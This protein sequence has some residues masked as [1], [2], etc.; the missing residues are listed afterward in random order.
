MPVKTEWISY[1]SRNGVLAVPERAALPLPA[2]I[3]IQEIWG[4]DEHIEDVTRRIAAAGYAALAPDL[5]TEH[6]ERPAALRRERVARAAG[7]SCRGIPPTA[8]RDQAAPRP[9]SPGCPSPSG[10]GSPRPTAGCSARSSACPASSPRSGRPSVTCARSAPRPGSSPSRASVS[11]WAAPCGAACVRGAE[12]AGA[13]VFY[14]A[15]PP[16]GEAG[17]DRLPGDRL[18]RR[19][20]RARQRRHPGVRG[21]HEQDR[22]SPSSTTSYEGAGHSFF[23]DTRPVV[24]GEGG[25]GLVRPPALAFLSRHPH[26]VGARR[27]PRRPRC[28]VMAKPAGPRCNLRCS[29]CYYVGRPISSTGGPGR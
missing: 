23:N 20:R 8:W 5:W 9:N 4:V 7:S 11:A 29:Y 18:L 3:V 17:P 26:R 28:L 12:L 10:P 21:R 27:W 1:G 15:T 6:G 19:G 16:P 25:A 2:V 14:G 13:A 24:R 22:P